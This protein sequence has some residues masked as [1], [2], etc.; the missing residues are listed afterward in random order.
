MTEQ[1]IPR[2]TTIENPVQGV[3]L[4]DAFSD[5]DA[6]AVQVLIDVR[7]G[8]SV[9]VK[10]CLPGGDIR[11]SRTCRTLNAY[12]NSW[13]QNAIACGN[14]TSLRIDN[15]LIQDM[16]QCPDHAACRAA[17]QFRVAVQGDYET[18]AG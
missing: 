11:Q 16:R 3:N 14:H 4:I 12:P 18:N 13:L 9:D 17:R 15:C 7:R 1:G 6:L 10:P 8:P 2:E 5:E